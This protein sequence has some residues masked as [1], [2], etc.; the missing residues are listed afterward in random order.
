[1]ARDASI[2]EALRSPAFDALNK[3]SI[4]ELQLA[5]ILSY[6]DKRSTDASFDTRDAT[7]QWVAENIDYV[8]S[9][10]PRGY[11][12]VVQDKV[13]A[14]SDP[15]FYVSLVTA[16]AAVC[17]VIVVA[18]GVYRYRRRRIFALAQVEFLFFVLLGVLLVAVGS[19]ARALP[20]SDVTCTTA[21]W[22]T[23]VG[24][25]LELVPLLLKVSAINRLMV[26]AARMKRVELNRNN[27]LRLVVGVAALVAAGM[28][29]WTIFDPNRKATE[30][31]MTGRSTKYLWK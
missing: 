12:R 22:P 27:L 2:P 26:A 3:Y 8:K 11:P 18:G 6:L 7:C 20:P 15:L 31:A 19:V 13:D 9:F 1:M 16:I 5:I 4:S 30:Y 10:I 14:R 17:L 28:A 23:N 29:T 21:P 25:T 24:Y